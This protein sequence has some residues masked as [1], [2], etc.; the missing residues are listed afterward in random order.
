M[1]PHL[2]NVAVNQNPAQ[3][4]TSG[5]NRKSVLLLKIPTHSQAMAKRQY[6]E[7]N[8]QEREV[9]C[10]RLE[11]RSQSLQSFTVILVEFKEPPPPFCL[12]I[13]LHKLFFQPFQSN[14]ISLEKI[15]CQLSVCLRQDWCKNVSTTF[16]MPTSMHLKQ[17]GNLANKHFFRSNFTL[18]F[19]FY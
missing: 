17:S 7:D 11:S 19:S 2:L 13:S 15:F 6:E 5:F 14:Y 12:L 3:L 16:Q 18:N 1:A 9:F 4:Y 10:R 8:C